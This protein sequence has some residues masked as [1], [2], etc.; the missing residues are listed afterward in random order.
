MQSAYIYP[1]LHLFFSFAYSELD[2][3]HG[4]SYA[5]FKGIY[6]DIGCSILGKNR[7]FQGIIPGPRIK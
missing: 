4:V 5:T 1:Y 6:I 7:M 2:P 3:G